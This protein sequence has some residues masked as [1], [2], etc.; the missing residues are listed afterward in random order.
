M[1]PRRQTRSEAG[2]VMITVLFVLLALLI[3]CAPFLA[4]ARNANK[5]SQNH[6]TNAQRRLALDSAARF[7]RYRLSHTHQGSPDETQFWDSLD[8]LKVE[9]DFDP[10][11]VNA[12]DPKG[13]MWDLDVRD[14]SGLIDLNSAGPQM[15]ANV[16]GLTTRLTEVIDGEAS[17]LPVAS[18][19]GFAPE[20][21]FVWVRGELIRY[22]KSGDEG[23]T[24]LDR[25]VGT[26]QAEDEGWLTEG[27]RPPSGHGIGTHVI[28]QRAFAPAIWR[29]G[30]DADPRT[31][32][33]FEQLADADQFALSGGMGPETILLLSDHCSV[34][35]SVRGGDRWQRPVRLTSHIEGGETLTISVDDPRYVNAGCTIWIGDGDASELRMVQGIERGRI[36][37]ESVLENDYD[38]W[39]TVVKVMRKR[40]VNLNTAP[41]NVLRALFLNLQI[42]GRNDRITEREADSLADLV[43]ESRPFEGFQDFLLRVVL[44]AAG[45]EELPEGAP[46]PESLPSGSGGLIDSADAVALYL[47]GLNANDGILAYS[48][49]PFCFV[50][51]DVYA[52]DLRASVNGV[53]GLERTRG[54]RERVEVVVPQKPLFTMWGTQ[55]DFDE[56]MRLSRTGLF[57]STG[58]ASTT[59]YDGSAVP[60]S[61]AWPNM[62]T[63]PSGPYLPGFHDEVVSDGGEARE[64]VRTF[65]SREGEDD[66]AQLWAARVQE[67]GRREQRMLHFDNEERDPEGRY[68]PDQ[69]IGRS[70][71]HKQVQWATDNDGL[72]RPISFEMWIK[73]EGGDGFL[74]DVQGAAPEVDRL[75]LAVEGEDL[76]LRVIDGFGDHRDSA[77]TEATEVRYAIAQGD[78]PGLPA[79]TWSHVAIDMQGTRPDQVDMLVNGTASGV[80]RLAMSRLASAAGQGDGTLYL[81][82]AEGFPARGVARVGNELIEFRRSGN[83]LA[84]AHEEAGPD[85]GF[86][87]RLARQRWGLDGIP[88][89]LGSTT[90][91]HPAG[92]M[93]Q[94]YGYSIPFTDDI[95]GGTGAKSLASDLGVFKVAKVVGLDG[96]PDPI[97][98]GAQYFGLGYEATNNSGLQLTLA[99]DGA[100]N[101]MDAFHPDGGYAM[102]CQ[103]RWGVDPQMQSANPPNA[104]LGGFEVVRYSGWSG[105]IL[106]IAARGDQVAG[107]LPYYGSLDP[108]AIGGGTRVFV[109]DW[110]ST[111]IDDQGTLASEALSWSWFVV[112]ISISVPSATQLDFLPPEQNLEDERSEFAQITNLDQAELTEWVR[113][114]TIQEQQ[115]QLVRDHPQALM[116]VWGTLMGGRGVERDVTGRPAPGGGGG[117]P[118]G[119]GPGG[120]PHVVQGFGPQLGGAAPAP[121]PTPKAYGTVWDPYLGESEL[122]QYP[123]SRAIWSVYQFRGVLGTHSHAQTGGALVTPVV[124]FRH[125][126]ADAGRIGAR[127]EVFLSGPNA[128][129]I[130]WPLVVHRAHIPMREDVRYSWLHEPGGDLLA[131]DG[132]TFEVEV[133]GS[134][135][136]G[137]NTQYVA[138]QSHSPEPFLAGTGQTGELDE[139][140]GRLDARLLARMVK[141]PSGERP[142][143]IGQVKIGGEAGGGTGQGSGGGG[144]PPTLVDEVLFGAPDHFQGVGASSPAER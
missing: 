29:L 11:F 82:D 20:G 41:R 81:E 19:A 87:G 15:L 4:T 117:G 139:A 66:F 128:D 91:D 18:D 104:P 106:Q 141:W 55:D 116:G 44:P 123:L 31:F 79:N 22:G 60:P 122:A 69:A 94:V 34:H 62:G 23:L 10:E 16:L 130:G 118:G 37:L 46:H 98:A 99:D 6:A 100:G 53:S 111:T 5:H 24:G 3:L 71:N 72:M 108:A 86:G 65:A 59:R 67:S 131:Q 48:T 121:Q 45:L 105:D 142:R 95:P 83:T 38:A 124:R 120:P 114:D 133:D 75:S 76:V 57:W 143:T 54:H 135:F 89:E 78:G 129:H 73:P 64:P 93:V 126:D 127:D 144:V 7:A 70:P 110:E 132:P 80:R 40:P 90:V 39:R 109:L 125:Q 42:D 43:V 119:G 68:L 97:L 102:L 134:D 25:G 115:G 85:A 140:W 21:G 88:E 9:I 32:D 33:S 1:Q 47:N 77:H 51:R 50:S 12:T 52:L 36:R 101:V 14:I 136:G 61:R 112:P 96:D 138:F 13:I 30:S 92:A 63:L 27:P 107:E 58:P 113:Y 28:D 103:R 35:G 84:C 2:F 8:E 26:T 137:L 74:L 56:A 17:S 49:M